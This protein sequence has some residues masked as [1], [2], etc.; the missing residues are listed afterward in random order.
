MGVKV[1]IGSCKNM[2]ISFKIAACSEKA[3]TTIPEMQIISFHKVLSQDYSHFYCAITGSYWPKKFNL[4]AILF[5]ISM[6]HVN[7]L[8]FSHCN[9]CSLHLNAGNC[10]WL[11]CSDHAKI[12]WNSQKWCS[13]NTV[14]MK[15]I[16]EP[17]NFVHSL[18]LFQLQLN[19]LFYR[20]QHKAF[21]YLKI[22]ATRSG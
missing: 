22:V 3:S 9:T 19:D 1:S 14:H 21:W 8:N 20:V 7:W 2:Y 16:H 6:W 10:V 5:S 18:V 15:Y 11:L 12:T 4:V 17:Q 13:I